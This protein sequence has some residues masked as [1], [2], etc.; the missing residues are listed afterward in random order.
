MLLEQIH[1]RGR[2]ANIHVMMFVI[3]KVRDQVVAGFFRGSFV[4][5]KFCA[6]VVVD[7][8]DTRALSREAPHAFRANQSRRTCND[9]GAC[10]GD[11]TSGV[12]FANHPGH[13]ARRGIHS[14]GG[15]LL[16]T[17]EHPFD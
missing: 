3:A 1:D 11:F 5:E 9:D 14:G 2:L 15:K 10:H 13:F 8:K 12:S 17:R 6:H 7:S 4:A 16:V